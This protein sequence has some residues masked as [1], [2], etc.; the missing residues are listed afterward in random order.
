MS[1]DTNF[2]E[3]SP[4]ESAVIRG[5]RQDLKEANAKVKT[6]GDDAVAK[7]KRAQT[8]ST[9]LPDEYKG[10]ADV[11][12][13]EVDGELTP[14]LAAGWLTGRGFAAPPDAGKEKAAEVAA[15]LEEV[16]NLGGAVAAAGDLTPENTI[17]A[18][19]AKVDTHDMTQTL[20]EVTAQIAAILNG[21]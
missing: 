1:D 19:L 8:A 9:L 21:Q 2:G 11:F 14:E 3:G 20:P 10:L 12:E 6:A 7:V 15:G 4:E 17:D 13:A 18:R 5:L 16:T